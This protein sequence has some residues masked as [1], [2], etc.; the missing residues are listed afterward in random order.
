MNPLLEVRLE[1]LRETLDELSQAVDGNL[2]SVLMRLTCDKS[3]RA[4]ASFISIDPLARMARERCLLLIAREHPLAS[5]LKFVMAVIRVS[6]D[7]ERIQELAMAL[8]KRIERLLGTPVQE[9]LQDMTGVM[10]DMLDMHEVV[11]RTWQRDRQD[12]SL[13]D[14]KLKVD[15]MAAAIFLR[16]KSIQTEIMKAIG[17]GGSSAETFVEVVLACRHVK[18]IATTMEAIPDDLHAFDKSH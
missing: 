3:M 7:Y 4:E 12:L 6:H 9:V 11:C 13:P 15:A 1:N 10:A 17:R 8:N 5:D 14:L 16:L 18:R 2:R